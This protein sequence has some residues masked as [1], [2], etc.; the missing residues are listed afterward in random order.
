MEVEQV[1]H[2]SPKKELSQN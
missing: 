2:H 1:Y